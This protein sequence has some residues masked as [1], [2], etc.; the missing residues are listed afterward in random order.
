MTVRFLRSAA[1]ACVT[2]LLVLAAWIIVTAL[3][4]V[5]DYVIPAPLAVLDSL[6]TTWPD[7]LG[8]A[9][10]LTATETLLGMVLGVVVAVAVVV[11]S[12]FVPTI[13]QAMTPL[14]SPPRPSR[15]S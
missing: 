13:G 11:V 3:E 12:A 6:V 1:P 8:S 10:V 2:V 14:R 7:R 4:L 9:T 15:S 5:P